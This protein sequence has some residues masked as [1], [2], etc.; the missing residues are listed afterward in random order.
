MA[1]NEGGKMDKPKW[2]NK[3]CNPFAKPHHLK[4]S[5]LRPVLQWMCEKLPT[6]TVGD[7]ICAGCRIEL[8]KIPVAE[9]NSTESIESGECS[10]IESALESGACSLQEDAFQKQE[11]L[12][13]L[14]QCLAAIGET[15]IAKKKLQQVKYPKEKIKKI[16]ASVKKIL[17]DQQSCD[18][19]SESEMIQQLKEKFCT[20]TK[21]SEK[22]QVLTV[23]P[24]SW[25]VRRVQSEFGASNYMVR[26]AKQLTKQKGILSTPNLKQGHQL[27]AEII[28]LVQEFYESDEVSRAMPGKKDFVSV[29]QAAGDGRIH[30][31]KRLVL[32]NLKEAYRLFKEKFPTK[33]IG[34]S[35][36]AELRPKQCILAGGSGTHN[37]CVCTI[38]Q[39]VQLMMNVG[40]LPECIV[41]EDVQ[42]KTYDHCLAHIVC[43]PPQPNCFF[44]FCSS[45]PGISILKE[46]L[47]TF[48]DNHLVDNVV[49]KQWVSVDRCT[50]ETFSKSA[51]DFV[52]AFCDKLEVL[53][54]HSFISRQQS[55]FQ[56]KIKSDLK[57]GEF[58]V[59]CDFAEN[60]SFV[61][62][63]AAQGFHWNNSQATIHPFVVYFVDSDKLQH[64]SY[65]VISDCLSHDTIAVHL[66]QK[67]LIDFLKEKFACL[68]LKIYYFSDGAA[69]QYKNRKNFLNLCHHA[70]DF[71]VPAEWHFSATAHGKGACDGVGGSV[72]RLA[73]RAS[74]Q[75]PYD[76]QI[77]TPRQLYEWAVQNLPAISF[78]YCSVDDYKRE[79]V[80][81]E[82][83]FDNSRTI[84]GT[85]KLHSFIPVSENK[86]CTRVYSLSTISK[87]E[88]VTIQENEL[89]LE[90]VSGFITCLHEEQWWVGCVLHVDEDNREVL[91]KFLHPHGPS[92]SFRYPAKENK[93]IVSLEN[94]LTKVDPRTT[95]GRVYTLTRA[96]S[97][98][99]TQKFNLLKK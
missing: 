41:G 87:V 33:N 77:M 68:P 50:L 44:N 76:D 6:L 89:A 23:L 90:D 3:C 48:M 73:A 56:S 7:K 53:L 93:I 71:G 4:K 92:P 15:P 5:N 55:S 39:N 20:T 97:K 46:A 79:E 21:R 67:N 63:D 18:T 17:P 52:D 75:R 16:K 64:V 40:G 69:S 61:L 88:R 85:R 66:F 22:V 9:V 13:S 28:S 57:P 1:C 43:N 49:Y 45:C 25:T 99:A 14:N 34:F 31:Q 10:L 82:K 19:D 29:K 65:V 12:K 24:K 27:S 32:S 35:K 11:S 84:P 91:V 47:K 86:V 42:L 26:T 80:L 58:L 30:L 37:V 38:H 70:L 95:T 96:E 94:I 60:Y 51:D 54:P 59:I 81:L 36:F 8:A 2:Q 62:Q 74:L 83:R 72:K 78:K 98:S